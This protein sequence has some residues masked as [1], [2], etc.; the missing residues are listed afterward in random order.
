MIWSVDSERF[1]LLTFNRG[2]S[3]YFLT[4]RGLHIEVGMDPGVL[5][6]TEEYAEKW[7]TF[8]RRALEEGSFTTE[9]PVYTGTRTLLLNFNRLERDG[10]VFGVSVFGQDITERKKAEEALKESEAKYR[11]L[12][13]S[14]M[15]G[16]VL[17]DMD[18]RILKYNES[19][20]DMT[21]YDTGRAAAADLPRH[22]A[23]E[24]ARRR[25]RDHR[26]AGAR[27]RL[28]RCLREGIPDERRDRLPDR[29]SNLSF[30]G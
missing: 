16:Y 20:R 13:D 8:Y 28:F 29:A 22:H 10:V 18:G 26:A 9:Y 6:P 12:Y 7:R 24:M 11:S 27:P 30:Q 19:Y 25:E 17:V 14:M 15:D 4:E 23:G 5:L 1:G 21:G 2:L 3:E